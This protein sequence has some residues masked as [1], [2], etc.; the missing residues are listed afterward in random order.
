MK[1]KIKTAKEIGDIS[2]KLKN[3]GKIIVTTNGCFDILHVGHLYSFER[4]KSLGDVLIVLL[5]SDES[6]KRIKGEKRPI[7]PQGQRAEILSALS[8]VDYVVIFDEDRPFELLKIIKPDKH[9]KGWKILSES[10]K[11]EKELVESL[12]GE[13]IAVD[14]KKDISTTNIINKIL[15][16]CSRKE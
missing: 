8:D 12:D 5:N 10:G 15:K 11:K 14:L 7:I 6:T 3:E 13:Y 1:N 4:A 9:I 16:D 2:R